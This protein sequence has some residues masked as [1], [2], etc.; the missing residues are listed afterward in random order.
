MFAVKT[1]KATI[2]II[3]GEII[4]GLDHAQI[5]HLATAKGVRKVSRRDLPVVVARRL[6]GATTAHASSLTGGNSL[7]A[8]LALLEN[9]AWLGAQIAVALAGS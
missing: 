9:N 8:N 5:E 1:P 6:D 2:G 3:G 4:V 7:R